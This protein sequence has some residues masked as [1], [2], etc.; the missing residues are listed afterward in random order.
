MEWI[1]VKDR[2]PENTDDVLCYF[3]RDGIT[4]GYY[5]STQFRRFKNR[6]GIFEV[7]DTGWQDNFPWAVRS[8]CSHWMPLPNAPETGH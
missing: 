1:S 5:D 7:T 6:E 2:L 4:V 3:P 8:S